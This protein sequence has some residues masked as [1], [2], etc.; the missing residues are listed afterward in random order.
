MKKIITQAI[1]TKDMFCYDMKSLGERKLIFIESLSFY[2]L[3]FFICRK[4]D[5]PN[6]NFYLPTKK[7][8]LQKL[9]LS[10]TRKIK[11]VNFKTC[12]TQFCRKTTGYA[13]MLMT[14]INLPVHGHIQK[15]TKETALMP[16]CLV[17]KSK[18]KQLMTIENEKAANRNKNFSF[19]FKL[20]KQIIH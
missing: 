12:F 11:F 5:T 10:N 2:F 8:F 20:E 15:F 9:A 4:C 17:K 19:S 6:V 13:D 1:L 3:A 14:Y 7:R 18:N 16:P